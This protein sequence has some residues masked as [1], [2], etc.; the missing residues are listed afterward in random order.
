MMEIKLKQKATVILVWSRLQKFMIPHKKEAALCNSMF[1]KKLTFSNEK[2]S[3][4]K[5]MQIENEQATIIDHQA[6]NQDS[7]QT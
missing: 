5:V 2:S 6:K 1:H 7:T 4:D 3:G